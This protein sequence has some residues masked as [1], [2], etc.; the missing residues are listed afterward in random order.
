[1]SELKIRCTQ[2]ESRNTRLSNDLRECQAKL[3]IRE[4]CLVAIKNAF[5]ACHKLVLHLTSEGNTQ[6]STQHFSQVQHDH[7]FESDSI[8]INYERQM[9]EWLQEYHLLSSLPLAFVD[10]H[11]HEKQLALNELY[12][13]DNDDCNNGQNN[14]Y[15]NKIDANNMKG[16]CLSYSAKDFTLLLCLTQYHLL[17]IFVK[18]FLSVG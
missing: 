2:L 11:L 1:M 13:D 15:Y 12:A 14:V 18:T 7:I 17:I 6:N 10:I 16:L 3:M 8:A 9:K 4:E 5:D